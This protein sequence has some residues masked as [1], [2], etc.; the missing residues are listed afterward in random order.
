MCY[1]HSK[2]MSEDIRNIVNPEGQ[3]QIPLR[4]QLAALALLA[5]NNI[6]DFRNLKIYPPK[7]LAFTVQLDKIPDLPLHIE[8]ISQKTELTQ[9]ISKRQPLMNDLIQSLVPSS[10]TITRSG[11]RN[12]PEY[13]KDTIDQISN[14]PNFK[15]DV[16]IIDFL[17]DSD[18]A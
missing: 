6:E 7:M 9:I 5:L 1:N 8:D 12:L 3:K 18:I 13:P 15:R 14:Q 10:E 16:R 2:F 17:L 11:E 4:N